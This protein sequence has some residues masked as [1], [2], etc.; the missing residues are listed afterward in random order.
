MNASGADLATVAR[1]SDSINEAQDLIVG[2]LAEWIDSIA[3]GGS[4][5]TTAAVADATESDDVPWVICIDDDRAFT[6]AL[7]RRLESAGVA[8]VRAFEGREGFRTA[9]RHPASAVILDYEMPDGQGDYV[10]RRLKDNPVTYDIPVIVITGRKDKTLERRMLNLGAAAYFT[11]PIVW[12]N[13]AAELRK[14][15]SLL[16]V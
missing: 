9:F 8:V 10:L 1:S 11:K 2:Q 7:K 14:H 16:A 13:L 15:I 3:A 6:W 5:T 4:S 12:C